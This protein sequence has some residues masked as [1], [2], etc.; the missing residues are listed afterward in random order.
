VRQDSGLQGEIGVFVVGVA[1]R[2]AKRALEGALVAKLIG[3]LRGRTADD[4]RIELK[5]IGVEQ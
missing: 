1:A 3:G 4:R 5:R 2:S